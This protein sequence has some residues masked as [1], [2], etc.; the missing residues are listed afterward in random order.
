MGFAEQANIC[1][2]NAKNNTANRYLYF[3]YCSDF[4]GVFNSCY[5]TDD[6]MMKKNRVAFAIG[7][8]LLL[9]SVGGYYLLHSGKV[10]E[11]KMQAISPA[12]VDNL[13]VRTALVK[14]GSINQSLET[15]GFVEPN[16]KLIWR[17]HPYAQGWIRYLANAQGELVQKGQL[18][19]QLYSPD[20]IVAEQAYLKALESKD[21]QLIESSFEELSLLNFSKKQIEDLTQTH[22]ASGLMDIYSPQKGIVTDL[23]VRDGTFVTPENEIMSLV[24]LTSVCIIVQIP[25]K[26][27]SWV[28]IGLSAQAKISAFPD[29]IWYPKVEYIYPEL[30]ATTRT[31]K[32]RFLIDNRAGLLKPNMYVNLSLFGYAKRNILIIPTEALIRNTKGDS[33]IVVNE[34]GHFQ[35]RDVITGIESGDHIEII[36][37]LKQGEKIVTSGQ[38][39]IDSEAN[40]KASTKRME[41]QD[42]P[43]MPAP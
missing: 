43:Q 1:G 29:K 15:L 30:D 24:D 8:I 9:G 4:D 35:A 36:S 14:K 6:A 17:I 40:L 42:P 22:N 16:A 37:G 10:D 39:L 12:M 2:I 32:V 27:A 7:F 5:A 33:V 20:V 31:L 21:K 25:E 26:Q 3:P 41:D 34:N 38:F 23:K 19:V 11:S 18:L 13:G 28:K